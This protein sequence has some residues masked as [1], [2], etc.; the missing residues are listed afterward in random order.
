MLNKDMNLYVKSDQIQ[1]VLTS[2]LL[3]TL[4]PLP[5]ALLHL[6]LPWALL[7]HNSTEHRPENIEVRFK[8]KPLSY[9]LLY[10]HQHFSDTLPWIPACHCDKSRSSAWS[11]PTRPTWTEP[12][13]CLTLKNWLHTRNLMFLHT[14]ELL[15]FC[16]LVYPYFRNN[17]EFNFAFVFK[18]S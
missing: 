2:P 13:H 5:W 1:A 9:V 16:S 17:F 14:F 11:I 10:Q 3:L 6:P 4:L 18:N 12:H 7:H 15:V 8:S